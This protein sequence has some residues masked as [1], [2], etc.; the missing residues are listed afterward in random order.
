MRKWIGV[1]LDGT[2]AKYNGWSG[3]ENIGDPVP[4]MLMRVKEWIKNGTVRSSTHKVE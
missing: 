4:L 3:I 1:D 2:L